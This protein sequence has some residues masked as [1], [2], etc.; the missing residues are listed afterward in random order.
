MSHASPLV[1]VVV[2]TRG[3][4]APLARLTEDLAPS[5]DAEST[6]S[7]APGRPTRPRPRWAPRAPICTGWT[8]R[9]GEDCN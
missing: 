1:S 5:L 3:D 4:A 7:A 9:P 8:A 6:S 2:P